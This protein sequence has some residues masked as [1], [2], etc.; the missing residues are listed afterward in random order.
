M[1]N[2]LFT[3]NLELEK[4]KALLWQKEKIYKCVSKQDF[5][6]NFLEKVIFNS[7]F[8]LLNLHWDKIKNIF[9]K[10]IKNTE[11]NNILKTNVKKLYFFNIRI[12]TNFNVK[13]FY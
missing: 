7:F 1:N 10:I 11:N 3:F 12:Q 2:I 9:T 8:N 6:Q 4:I 13:T 5:I